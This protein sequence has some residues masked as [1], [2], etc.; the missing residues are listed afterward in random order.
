[1]LSLSPMKNDLKPGFLGTL[2]MTISTLSA[3]GEGATCRKFRF[4]I[5]FSGLAELPEE[6]L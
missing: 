1:M 5:C 4:E 3:A 2:G 6:N